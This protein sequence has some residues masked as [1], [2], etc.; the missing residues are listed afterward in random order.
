MRRT[1]GIGIATL[2]L[3][4]GC[5]E[6]STEIVDDPLA[7][8]AAQTRILLTDAPFPYDAVGSVDIYIVRVAVS[9]T[10]DTG[11][12]ADDQAWITVAEPR[13]R[14]DL[15]T[16]RDGQTALLGEFP[17]SA[18]QYKALRLVLNADSSR[19]TWKNG[20]EALVSWQGGGEM[21]LNSVVEGAIDV[22]DEGARIVIDF[23][24]GRSFAVRTGPAAELLFFPYLRA[25][26]E[27]STGAIVGMVYGA[28]GDLGVIPVGGGTVSVFRGDTAQP[29]G[30]WSLAATAPVDSGGRYA[31]HFLQVRDYIVQASPP[32]GTG[33]Q[34][35][36]IGPVPV[37]AGDTTIAHVVLGGRSGG[38]GI[39]YIRIAGDTS[40]AVGQNAFL[41]AAVFD[42]NGDSV[43]T[44]AV[45]W[46]SSDT[47][48]A[49]ITLPVGRTQSQTAT[50]TGVS[51]GTALIT[52]LQGTRSGVV[53]VSVGDTLPPSL[54]PVASVELSPASQTLTVGD[55]AWVRAVLRD[56][57]GA[58]LSNRVVTW[59][60]SKANVLRIDGQFGHYLIFTAITADTVVVTGT[61]EGKSSAAVVAV[62]P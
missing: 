13:Q 25:V 51:V 48:V 16:L 31:V 15:L 57:A 26:N 24:V 56:S 2:G 47:S 30:T 59:A 29:P 8:P 9:T 27:A 14:Y 7:A 41:F 40:L 3:V 52:A 19:V 34:P 6:G 23:D 28:Q 46:S 12:S 49:R 11:T 22:P 54:A 5:G 37:V 43:V 53:A 38:T 44:D 17:L 33:W 1:W 32:A 42:A 35:G 61:S 50:V 60:I 21:S 55:S 10:A 45:T 58:E 62:R 39:G 20:T 18:G 4:V 36:T